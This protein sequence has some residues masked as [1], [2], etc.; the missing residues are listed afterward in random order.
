MKRLKRLAGDAACEF[1]KDGMVVGLGTGS[2][3]HYTIKKL[4]RMVER[5]LRIIGIPTSIKTEN[6]ARQCKVTLSSLNE[7]PRVDVSIDGADEVD[8]KLNLIKG[9]G[10]ALV[11]EKIVASVSRRLIIVVDQSKQVSSLGSKSPVP[12][13]V[14][15]FGWSAAMKR[16]EKLGGEVELRRSRKIPF[17]SDNGNYIL[18]CRFKT[19]PSPKRLEGKLNN[20]PGVVENGL[21]VNLANLVLMGTDEGVK[22]IR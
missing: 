16:I 12:V 3:V 13:E 18:D 2:T 14:L 6:L 20:I 10:G 4:G 22:E 15:P 17:V 5:G 11:R 8:P 19:I 9:L 7:H 1:V 21:F